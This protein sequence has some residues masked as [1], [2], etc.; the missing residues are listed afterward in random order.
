MKPYLISTVLV[1]LL[2]CPA[3]SALG[4]PSESE[5]G[6]ALTSSLGESGAVQVH[7]GPLAG[8]YRGMTGLLIELRKGTEKQ[9]EGC[10][11]KA[12][13]ANVGMMIEPNG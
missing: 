3:L 8:S 4:A 2:A 13:R 1:A 12:P 10:Y 9:G 5:A 11:L 6:A 7:D